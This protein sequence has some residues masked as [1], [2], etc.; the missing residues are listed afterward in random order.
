MSLSRLYRLRESLDVAEVFALVYLD[1]TRP[2]SM[3]IALI[4]HED[5]EGE[6]DEGRVK[7]I[8]PKTTGGGFLCELEGQTLG[9]YNLND[10]MQVERF[11]RHI[12]N[13]AKA[14]WPGKSDEELLGLIEGNCLTI[15]GNVSG[16]LW[17]DLILSWGVEDDGTG[18]HPDRER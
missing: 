7:M 15:V 11:R 5:F 18:D 16:T 13:E 14:Q 8:N 12:L 1:D 17:H 2:I 3:S 6:Q 4:S 10:R 9:G